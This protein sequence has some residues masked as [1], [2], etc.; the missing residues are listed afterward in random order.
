MGW[1]WNDK[2]GIISMVQ[3]YGIASEYTWHC[4]SA[5]LHHLHNKKW[6]GVVLEAPDDKL[7]L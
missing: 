4:W 1:T 5:E 3:Q 7:E 2:T 6:Y